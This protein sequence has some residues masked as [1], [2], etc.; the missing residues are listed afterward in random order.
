MTSYLGRTVAAWE[1]RIEAAREADVAFK[2]GR[3][4]GVSE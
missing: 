4:D 2:G 1:E 3:S